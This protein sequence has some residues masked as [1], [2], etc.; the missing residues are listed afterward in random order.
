MPTPTEAKGMYSQSWLNHIFRNSTILPAN[1]VQLMKT[2][3]LLCI[4][5]ASDGHV[6]HRTKSTEGKQLV[7]QQQKKP[8][9][10]WKSTS[11]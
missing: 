3:A 2:A 8:R 9:T 7:E 5:I 6:H 10:V 11:K 4:S 1:R